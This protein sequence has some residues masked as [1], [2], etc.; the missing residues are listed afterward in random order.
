M[1]HSRARSLL[2]IKGPDSYPMRQAAAH[3]L[4]CL[5]AHAL[6]QVVHVLVPLS[7]LLLQGGHLSVGSAQL[8]LSLLW[9]HRQDRGV[10]TYRGSGATHMV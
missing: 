9:R 3:P 10:D 5:V 6:L 4:L 1:H 8:T 2:L 7:Q